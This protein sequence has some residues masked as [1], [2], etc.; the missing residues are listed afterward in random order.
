MP[1]T[2]QPINIGNQVN[3]GLGDDLRSAFAKVNANFAS[4]N[5]AITI[6]ATNVGGVG[7]GV[8]KDQV[9]SVL[10]FRKL[11]SGRYMQ[12]E[13]TDVSIVF[14]NTFPLSFTRID[15]PSGNVLASAF[16]EITIQ[17]GPDIDVSALG[18]S[19]RINTHLPLSQIITTYDFG[20]LTG[21]FSNSMQLA[22]S[23]ANVEFGRFTAPSNINLDCGTI[24][25]PLFNP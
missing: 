6:T 20:K 7:S 11:V 2:L 1:T 24:I 10:E 22:L 5:S 14:N 21:K 18:S 9:D 13:E 12:L 16:Q 4:L 25:N 15:T 23:S 3:D 17:G 8:Y 19:V